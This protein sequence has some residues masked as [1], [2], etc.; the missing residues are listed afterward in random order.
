MTLEEIKKLIDANDIASVQEQFTTR[1]TEVEKN[2]KQYNIKEHDVMTNINRRDKILPAKGDQPSKTVRQWRI[3]IPYQ[4]K[5]VDSAV[6]FLFGKPVQLIEE[7]KDTKEAFAVLKDLWKDMRMHALN[8]ESA[9][10][11]FSQTEVARLFVP[12]HDNQADASD[13]TKANRVR[14]ILLAQSLGDT[15][16]TDFDIYGKMQ[17]FARK[18]F[19]TEGEE[20]VEH[21]DIYT[22]DT[23]YKCT[24]KGDTWEVVPEK[25]IINKIPVTYYKQEQTEWEDVQPM[26]ERLEWLMSTRADVNDYSANPILILE[27][28][29][30]DLPDKHEVAKVVQ[31]ENGGKASYLTPQMA[32]EMVKDERETLE[33][34]IRFCTDTPDLAQKEDRQG[35]QISGIA[36]M[37]KFF[38]AILKAMNKQELWGEMLDREINILK[39]YM[40]A[41]RVGV[42]EEVKTYQ[43]QVKKLVVGLEFGN[44]LPNNVEETIN[45]LSQ[46]TGGKPIMSQKAAQSMNPLL[47]DAEDDY[48][49]LQAEQAEENVTITM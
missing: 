12:Y 30:I 25:N 43:S 47:A 44:P 26:I 22:A 40:L 46:A 49:Q 18:Y 23:I 16:Y 37:M 48:A 2:L 34:A 6:A 32:I 5:I 9:R 45:L 1:K 31:L 28:Q 13:P 35:T 11:L 24:K 36:L 17:A 14:C 29:V 15:L 19:V 33:E 8:R 27:G 38:P 3:P 20:Q 41:L 21:F 39:A 4:K 42:T 10:I 7:S